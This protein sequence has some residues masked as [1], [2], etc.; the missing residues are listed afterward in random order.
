MMTTE[1]PSE[2]RVSVNLSAASRGP[3]LVLSCL[4]PGASGADCLGCRS[5]MWRGVARHMRCRLEN[6][7]RISINKSAALS[8]TARGMTPSEA[9]IPERPGRPARRAAARRSF[10]QRRPRQIQPPDSNFFL[11]T[12]AFYITQNNRC[13]PTCKNPGLGV[14]IS[15][16]S[17]PI[18]HAA[19]AYQ[20]GSISPTSA[21]WDI[22]F[23]KLNGQAL[24]Q[25]L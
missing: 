4:G 19:R 8:A 6:T 18:L 2:R 14:Q 20:L 22:A 16:T 25:Q 12:A 1:V 24:C 15:S 3:G 23:T 9:D 5:G 21:K 13:R 17:R 7:S 11:T 10:R